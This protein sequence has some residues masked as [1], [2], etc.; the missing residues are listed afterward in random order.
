MLGSVVMTLDDPVPV[1]GRGSVV[2]ETA[3]LVNTG[4]GHRNGVTGKLKY[5]YFINSMDPIILMLAFLIL[6]E[7]C[8]T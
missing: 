7:S 3:G 1:S 5:R 8:F 4:N 6:L 2:S